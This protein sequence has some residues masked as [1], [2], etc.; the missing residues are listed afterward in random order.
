[1]S[2]LR[3]GLLVVLVIA[4][5]PEDERQQARLYDR[6][7]A[8]AHWTITF[9]DRNGPTCIQAGELWSAFLKKAEFGAQMAYALALRYTA[10]EDGYLA[11]AALGTARG[12]L[13]PQD[14]KPA[15]RGGPNRTGV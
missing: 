15:W 12:T 13:T 2:I 7:A 8:A 1:M 4:V 10:R 9:C 6:A 14:L 5:L 11:P 3:I